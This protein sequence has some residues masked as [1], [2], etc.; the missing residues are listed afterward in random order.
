M[1]NAAFDVIGM[2]GFGKDFKATLDLEGEGALACKALSEGDSEGG[3]TQHEIRNVQRCSGVTWNAHRA[4]V[5]H[6]G[7]CRDAVGCEEAAGFALLD[8]LHI[9]EQPLNPPQ[10]TP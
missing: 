6:A 2:F 4:R 1:Q 7:G 5:C 8:P 9:G 10:S 3:F